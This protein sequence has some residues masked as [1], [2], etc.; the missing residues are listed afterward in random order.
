MLFFFSTAY[1]EVYIDEAGRRVD[2]PAHPKRIVS[3]A[4]NITETLFYLGLDKEIVGVTDFSDYP[5]A[6]LSKPKVGSFINVS[7]ERVVS[8]NP[9][10]I[11]GTVGGNKKEIV[12]RLER[13]GFPV[14][15]INP[16]SF[17]RIFTSVLNIG[18]VTGKEAEAKILVDGLRKRIGSVASL[19]KDLKKPRVFFQLGIDPIV[20]AGRDTLHNKL[21]E[22]AGG[23]NVTGDV[24]IKYPR[25]SVEDVIVKKPEIIMVSTM[26]RGEYFPRVKNGWKKWKNIPAVRDDK[27][28]I[29]E[30]DWIDHSSPRIV[31][32]LERLAVTIHPELKEHGL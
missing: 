29:I 16:D 6:A 23:M 14:Y 31:E 2:I 7:I 20:S 11:I 1:A 26:K 32:G 5:Q 19:T 18:R 30:S 28:Y 8:L 21:V 22:L 4:P 25:C 10:L 15:V 24:A 27:I 12:E 9:D 17:E 13:L 3:L